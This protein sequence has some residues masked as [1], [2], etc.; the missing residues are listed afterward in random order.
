MYRS[1]EWKFMWLH[2]V[3]SHKW[4]HSIFTSANQSK[5]KTPVFRSLRPCY[6]PLVCSS[7]KSMI[8]EEY[9]RSS[10][11]RVKYSNKKFN[12]IIIFLL[13]VYKNR[14]VATCDANEKVIS[15]W[16]MYEMHV[17]LHE[18]AER[19]IFSTLNICMN[20]N[21]NQ[22]FF[23]NTTFISKAGNV[24]TIT[25]NWHLLPSVKLLLLSMWRVELLQLR[26]CSIICSMYTECEEELYIFKL[27]Y[28]FFKTLFN[29]F[30][31]FL[32]FCVKVITFV[33][34]LFTLCSWREWHWKGAVATYYFSLSF[35]K[36]RSLN[37]TV[38]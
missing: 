30:S 31:L 34:L 9:V 38:W 20:F 3:N 13:L 32:R 37:I 25:E 17:T 16:I 14:N 6:L 26:L 8:I 29:Y 4:F 33:L 12:F 18:L 11:T 21:E 7:G 22:F 15:T 1:R 19:P 27:K 2:K 10:G 35:D 28:L 36:L 5:G 23:K 24:E